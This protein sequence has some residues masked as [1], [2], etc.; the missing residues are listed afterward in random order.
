[1]SDERIECPRCSTRVPVPS[2]AGSL[3]GCPHCHCSAALTW[4]T[5]GPVVSDSQA[6]PGTVIT[7]VSLDRAFLERYRVIR[8]LGQGA[9]SLVVL[10]W[11]RELARDVALKLLTRHKGDSV[12]RFQREARLLCEIEHHGV[13]RL[14]DVIQLGEYPC[15]V[16]E[17]VDG[18]SLKDRLKD[19]GQLAFPQAIDLLL[20]ALDALKSCHDRGLVH[21]DLKPENILIRLDG[22]SK[23]ADFGLAKLLE[24]D[25]QLLTQPGTVLGTPLYMSPEQIRGEEAGFPCDVYAVAEILFELLSG[26]PPHSGATLSELL[27]S[28]MRSVDLQWSSVPGT[29]PADLVSIIEQSLSVDPARRPTAERLLRTITHH[30][31]GHA[32]ALVLES[33]ASQVTR[34]P[35]RSDEELAAQA[36]LGQSSAFEEIVRR[37]QTRVWRL[38]FALTGNADDAQDIAQTTFVRLLTNLSPAKPVNHFVAYL[39]SIV[40]H[41][42]QDRAA[43]KTP[44]PSSHILETAA[45]VSSLTNVVDRRLMAQRLRETLDLLPVNQRAA[46]VLRYYSG[47]TTREIAMSM[48][49]SSKAVERLLARARKNL[50]T[51][52]EDYA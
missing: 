20:D 14:Y 43:K 15:L 25:E 13:V 36:A 4:V 49:I 18:G 52:L 29:V 11:D 51:L 23:I 3:V 32:R 6:T 7:A 40:I 9:S 2:T 1:M 47:L 37:H 16:T 48:G 45:P 30:S 24:S 27:S 33:S 34:Q 31:G 38:A 39:R 50:E 26:H 21:R 12:E 44:I 42:C 28:K 17:F 10:A 35:A 41:L 5:R 46:A 8:S 22:H 19:E